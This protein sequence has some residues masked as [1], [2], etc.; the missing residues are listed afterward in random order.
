M[1]NNG[2]LAKFNAD[3]L[4]EGDNAPEWVCSL[5]A[6]ADIEQGGY[7]FFPIMFTDYGIIIRINDDRDGVKVFCVS[8]DGKLL[9]M[10]FIKCSDNDF[11]YPQAGETYTGVG[12]NQSGTRLTVLDG[13]F[14]FSYYS[15]YTINPDA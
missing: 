13:S 6:E 4:V 9:W 15:Y 3:N 5:S 12:V 11:Q 8:Y 1:T 2:I 14:D 10:E 7:N